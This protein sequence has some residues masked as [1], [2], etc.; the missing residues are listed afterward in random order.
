V[1]AVVV[2]A[3]IP[4]SVPESEGRSDKATLTSQ[5]GRDQR[6]ALLRELDGPQLW[7][8]AQLVALQGY[9]LTFEAARSLRKLYSGT[10]T[11]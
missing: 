11:M 7:P 4:P 6:D 9:A 8:D 1:P 10:S 2:V 3:S 5:A